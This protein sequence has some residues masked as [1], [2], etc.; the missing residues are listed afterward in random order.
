MPSPRPH[1][2]QDQTQVLCGTLGSVSCPPVLSGEGPKGVE[3]IVM[4]VLVGAWETEEDKEFQ[5]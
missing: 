1:S 2:S 5:D 3:E 4:D